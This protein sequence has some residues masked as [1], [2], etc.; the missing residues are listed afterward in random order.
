MILGDIG[1]RHRKNFTI[2]GDTA[3]IAS[4]LE[5]V[6]RKMD[7]QILISSDV[8]ARLD[9]L[10]QDQ[11]IRMGGLALKGKTRSVEAWGTPGSP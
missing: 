8:Y 1:S 5:G 10:L 2:I 6:T 7:S 11:F 9:P 4:R 3:N